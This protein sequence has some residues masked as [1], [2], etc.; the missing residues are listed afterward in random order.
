MLRLPNETEWWD[1]PV[2]DFEQIYGKQNTFKF[3]GEAGSWLN[4]HGHDGMFYS[5]TD[6]SIW[7]SFTDP[8]VATLFKL[9][10]L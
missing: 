8:Q 4:E 5:N 10:W 2:L 1:S 7:I 9:T 3:T 6:N